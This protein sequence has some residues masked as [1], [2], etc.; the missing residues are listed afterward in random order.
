MY[1]FKPLELYPQRKD[2]GVL[3]RFS[4]SPPDGDHWSTLQ[5]VLSEE[6]NKHGPLPTWLG[7][8]SGKLWVVRGTPWRE[9]RVLPRSFL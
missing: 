3:V 8:G 1:N 4:Y 2:G 5:T 6:I 7:V 9:V